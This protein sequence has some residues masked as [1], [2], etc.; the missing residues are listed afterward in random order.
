MADRSVS[1]P[2]TLS[3]PKPGFQGHCIVEYLKTVH[4]TDKFTIEH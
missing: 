1:V 3:D 4:F 2:M